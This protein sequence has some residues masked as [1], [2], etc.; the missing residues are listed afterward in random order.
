MGFSAIFVATP[1]AA[2]NE[3]ALAQAIE[4]AERAARDA[5]KAATAANEAVAELRAQQV[6]QKAEQQT[7]AMPPLPKP[8]RR[9]ATPRDDTQRVSKDDDYNKVCANKP[10]LT[11][12]EYFRRVGPCERTLIGTQRIN[13]FK[14]RVVTGIGTSISTG[15]SGTSAT[16][17]I[18]RAQVSRKTFVGDF[19]K[20]NHNV[21]QQRSIRTNLEFGLRSDID[22][23]SKTNATIATFGALDRLQSNIAGSVQFGQSYSSAEPYETVR[24][25]FENGLITFHEKEGWDSKSNLVSN[26]AAEVNAKLTKACTDS[27]EIACSG[28]D[29]LEWVFRSKAWQACRLEKIVRKE[30]PDFCEANLDK[31]V[32]HSAEF[33]VD[34]PGEF[35][36]PE[37][38]KLYNTVFWGPPPRDAE[39]R[40]GWMLR[41][42]AARPSFNY[43]PFALTKVADPF[44]PGGTKTVI[45]PALFPPD[46][47]SRVTK[48]DAR[49]NLALTARA[50]FHLS[51]RRTFNQ[52]AQSARGLRRFAGWSLG[53]TVIGSMTYKREDA[54]E[55]AFKAVKICPPASAGQAFVTEQACTALNIAAPR[56]TEGAVL[57]GELRQG[58]EPN[59]FLPPTLVSGKLSYDTDTHEYGAVFPIYFA[60]DDKG[61]FT[62]GLR[63]AHTWNRIN[64][65]GSH[66]KPE[67]LLGVV[68]GASLGL[69]AND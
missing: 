1:A 47:A 6:A 29:L 26:R 58:I 39:P 65:D 30:N 23:G 67:T 13:A 15:S 51:R 22:K 24:G 61:V 4:R 52:L 18:G 28:P 35:A 10:S 9:F 69:T 33:D 64:G 49:L 43:Y 25:S 34:D 19:G 44:K 12:R 40:W 11:S 38:L 32:K 45:D 54:I 48:D 2:Q 46:F 14:S 56:R 41:A 63:V 36:N 27:K 21:E 3:T 31:W 53:S 55:E 60:A 50:F 37:A 57:A 8:G 68:I 17:T 59:R 42:E 16:F 62:G 7:A 66:K 5:Q 20:A